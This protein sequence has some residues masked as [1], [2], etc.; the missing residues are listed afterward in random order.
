MKYIVSG[1]CIAPMYAEVELEADTPDQAIALAQARF[2][3]D[4]GSVLVSNSADE[5]SAHDWQR[6][7]TPSSDCRRRKTSMETDFDMD[8]YEQECRERDIAA[9]DDDAALGC[10]VVGC[11]NG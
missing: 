3:T 4:P 7:A 11:D 2:K 6:D 5:G 10:E 1:I 9:Y 8:V